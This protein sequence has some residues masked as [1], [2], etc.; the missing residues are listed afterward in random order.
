MSVLERK[1]FVV[2][3]ELSVR[4]SLSR[5]LKAAGFHVET[6]ASARDFLRHGIEQSVSCLVLDMQMPEL[7]G[8]ELQELGQSGLV[9]ALVID[10]IGE[11]LALRP[12]E[13]QRFGALVV[14]LAQQPRGLV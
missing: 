8:L 2:D 3:D 10:E 14:T 1:V 11:H 13:A 6:F 12:G 9:D 7:N 4:K 5:L